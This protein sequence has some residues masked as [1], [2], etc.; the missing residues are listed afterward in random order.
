MRS[1]SSL[2]FLLNFFTILLFLDAWRVA[3]TAT[4]HSIS[5]SSGQLLAA[6]TQT[7]PNLPPDRGSQRRS[8]NE[9]QESRFP[10]LL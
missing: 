4:A 9:L 2:L 6:Q 1:Y 5:A 8:F 3:Y 10:R 7:R